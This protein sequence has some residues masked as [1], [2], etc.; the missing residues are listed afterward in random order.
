LAQLSAD[1]VNE[2]SA[3]QVAPGLGEDLG[4]NHDLARS[5]LDP[6]PVAVERRVM[7]AAQRQRV[8]DLVRGGWGLRWVDVRT[9]NQAEVEITHRT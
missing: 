5:R 2:G 4:V 3:S 1:G 7:I 8:P 9:F 6:D